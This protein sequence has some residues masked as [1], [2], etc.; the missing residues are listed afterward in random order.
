MILMRTLAGAL[1][2]Q[3]RVMAAYAYQDG[4][5]TRPSRADLAQLPRHSA[6]L[7]N[8]FD[9]GPA[10]GVGLGVTYRDE[11]FASTSN[12]VV[13]DAFTRVDAALYYTVNPAVQL[14][15]NV[16]NLLDEAYFLNAHSDNNLMPG[17]PRAMVL[18]AHFPF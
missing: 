6:S 8:R 18:T 10:W 15:L 16:E 1:T 4:A 2:P 13:L 11:V 14:Q 3:W 17:S 5:I 7:W 12:R 9:L